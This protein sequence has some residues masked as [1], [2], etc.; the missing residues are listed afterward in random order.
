ME[1]PLEP[2]LLDEEEETPTHKSWILR[3]CDET[4]TQWYAQQL[5][6][7]PLVAR[8]LLQRGLTDLDEIKTF[9]NPSLNDLHDPFFMK[10]MDKAVDLVLS[11]MEQGQKI[12][13]HGDY[14]VDG[15]SSVSVL[16][17][18]LRDIGAQVS[19]FIP[20]REIEGYGLNIETVRRLRHEGH[21]LLIT[22]DCGISN[23]DEIRLAKSLGLK[24]IVVDHHTIPEV[25][26]PAD[27]ILN[28]LQSDCA[29][30]F[31][32]LAAVGVTFNL[33]IA[34]RSALRDKGIFRFVPEPDLKSYLDLVALG[35]VADVVPL[36]DE[37]R[38][39]TRVGLEVLSKRRRAG[40]SALFER[41]NIEVKHATTQTI[42][43]QL[44]P[45]L[46][47]AGRMGDAALGVELLTT[48]SYARAVE[49]ANM[50]EELNRERQVS[51]RDIFRAALIQAEEQV[52]LGRPILVL[53]GEGWNRGVL[54]IVASQLME[55]F[56]RP[57]ILIGIE[58]GVGKGS[59][60][61]VEGVNLIEALGQVEELLQTFGGHTVAAGL[62]LS[63][64]HI[65]AFRSRLPLVVSHLLNDQPL[66]APVLRIDAIVDLEDL[67][68]EL[69]DALSALAPFGMGNPEPVFM[70][71]PQRASKIQIIG[72]RHLRARF[73]SHN[74]L[75]EAFGYNL[76]ESRELLEDPVVLAY[77]PKLS[78]RR[79][80]SHVELRIK[81]L[82]SHQ[83]TLPD[84]TERIDLEDS[85][86]AATSEPHAP[87]LPPT[88]TDI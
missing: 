11:T 80:K 79:G 41:A 49:L 24:T 35:T 23:V 54:G 75:V 64:E 17:E 36:V 30:P 82:R 55:R 86:A 60:R 76:S 31:K 25:L 83:A 21:D 38:I 4:I 10:D 6:Q 2:E 32:K 15:V 16:Y 20:R 71:K 7:P 44:A 88:P 29:F 72:K 42:S 61:S 14:D 13:V 81:D 47:A 66:P 3:T 22:T 33:V 9:L 18:F 63:A 68:D 37:N 12:V 85:F 19:Y 1:S 51:S 65:D 77:V 5:D 62:A 52:A 46:N 58:D 56:H 34:L 50:L 43:F 27:A 73:Y 59:A 26:P 70:S 57:A 45:R 8:L 74:Q 40:I 48:R 69:L 84:Q 39:F 67:N 87:A 28:P 78:V 53:A